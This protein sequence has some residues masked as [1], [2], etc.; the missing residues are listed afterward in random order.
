MGVDMKKNTANISE[1]AAIIGRIG[2][3]RSVPKG[4]SNPDVQ[5]K[6]QKTLARRR[7]KK[8]SR[9]MTPRGRP[10]ANTNKGA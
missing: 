9:S 7:S 1:A 5:A 2:G 6:A 3:S 8:V 4:F 10:K